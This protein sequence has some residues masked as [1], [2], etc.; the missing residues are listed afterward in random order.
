MKIPSYLLQIRRLWI[1]TSMAYSD[2]DDFSS[3]ASITGNS[4]SSV[5]TVSSASNTTK[6]IFKQFILT[7]KS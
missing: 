5:T 2:D 1:K 4:N 6:A 7:K 3:I